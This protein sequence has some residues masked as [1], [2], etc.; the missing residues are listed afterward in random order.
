MW[1]VGFKFGVQALRFENL[2]RRVQGLGFC[3]LRLGCK[4]LGSG[5]VAKVAVV[6]SYVETLGALFTAVLRYW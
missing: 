5:S 3:A 2:R 4:V 6:M 1:C